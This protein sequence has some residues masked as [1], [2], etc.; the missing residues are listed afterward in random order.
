[1]ISERHDDPD[2]TRG[3]LEERA[4]EAYAE[5]LGRHGSDREPGETQFA[6]LLGGHPEL[7]EELLRIR[8]G[9]GVF[10]SLD[11]E[12]VLEALR[13]QQRASKR[14]MFVRVA[15]AALLVATISFAWR[16]WA[17][18]RRAAQVAA[19]PQAA[20][21]QLAA[22]VV[23]RGI[24]WLEDSVKPESPLDQLEPFAEDGGSGGQPQPDSLLKEG[25]ADAI[26]GIAGFYRTVDGLAAGSAAS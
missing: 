17:S 6:E 3:S 12:R 18:V 10:G 11:P 16:S 22:A 13:G 4:V 9:L 20:S 19:E 23:S 15:A 24:R 7:R 25:S 21:E 2:A 14:T 5:F 26:Q 1:M 8:S